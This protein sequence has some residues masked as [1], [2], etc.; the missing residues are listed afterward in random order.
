M[1]RPTRPRPTPATRAATPATAAQA[2]AEQRK[3]YLL[4]AAVNVLICLGSLIGLA[5]GRPDGWALVAMIAVV[6]ATIALIS[7]LRLVKLR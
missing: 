7:V 2:L 3:G 5:V 1:A 4:L 6:S